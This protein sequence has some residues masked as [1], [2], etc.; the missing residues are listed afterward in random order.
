MVAAKRVVIAII[1]LLSV[2]LVAVSSFGIYLNLRFNKQ[3]G[4]V[5]GVV[6]YENINGNTVDVEV[7]TRYSNDVYFNPN[8]RQA[9][10]LYGAIEYKKQ[11]MQEDVS[12]KLT[13]F[14]FSVVAA[15]CVE[16]GNF[17]YGTMKSLYNADYDDNYIRISYL[18]VLASKYGIHV[19]AIGQIDASATNQMGGA[20]NDYHF[21]EYFAGKMEED[22]VNGVQGKVKDYLNFQK[23]YWTSYGDRSAADMM[24]FKFC[25]VSHMLEDGKVKRYGLWQTSTNLDALDWRGSN[26]ND[27][28][29]AGVVIWGHKELYTITNNVIEMLSK[30]CGQEEAPFYRQELIS[31]T[32]EQVEKI[33]SGKAANIDLN[34]QVV[35]LGTE[36]DQVFEMYFTP[37][38]SAYG[39]WDLELNPYSKYISK[40]ANSTDYIIFS[41]INPNFNDC[42]F[43]RIW[44]ANILNAFVTVNNPKSRLC[45]SYNTSGFDF[46]A[47]KKGVNAEFISINEDRKTGLH[48]KDAQL[49]YVE[50]GTRQFVSILSTTNIHEGAFAYQANSMIVIKENENIGSNFFNLFG[51]YNSFGAIK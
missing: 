19:T 50:N 17:Y 36:N 12:I 44:N 34:E 18:L 48:S 32:L 45:I 24:H 6:T 14:H 51:K 42:E 28:L 22:C 9:E 37:L 21:E 30:Y 35:Y 43:A 16:K 33:K 23:A 10:M 27:A 3:Q 11:H 4:A 25:T 47:I 15:A 7:L 1:C 26:G 29:Q 46:S 41:A 31:K 5:R 2:V 20:R 13:S 38:A 8:F 49:S 40:L 39:S